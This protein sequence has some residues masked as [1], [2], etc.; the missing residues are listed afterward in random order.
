[1]RMGAKVFR[2]VLIVVE[3]LIP[4]SQ[5]NAANIDLVTVATMA[6]FSVIMIL[7]VALG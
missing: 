3:E 7:D 1:M 6:G 5:R 2:S 4:E